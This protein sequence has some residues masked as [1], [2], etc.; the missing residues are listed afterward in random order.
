M[1]FTGTV[2]THDQQPFVIDRMI[3]LQLGKNKMRKAV[4]HFVGNDIGFDKLPGGTGFV[5]IA[6]LNN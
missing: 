2:V 5:C 3:E 4:S 1:R 6:Q